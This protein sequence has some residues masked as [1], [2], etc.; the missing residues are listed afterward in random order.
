M[1]SVSGGQDLATRPRRASPRPVKWSAETAAAAREEGDTGAREAPATAAEVRQALPSRGRKAVRVIRAALCLPAPAR[2][3]GLP[4]TRRRRGPAGGV[5]HVPSTS[6]VALPR[7]RRRLA[8]SVGDGV[9][10]RDYERATASQL[11]SS[12]SRRWSAAIHT[13]CCEAKE[14]S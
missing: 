5:R 6:P 4:H 9:T 8:R 13:P 10:W 11:L 7:Q 3:P 2:S 1:P 12:R 14:T